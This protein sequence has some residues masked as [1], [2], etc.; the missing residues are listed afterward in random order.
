MV[1]G[2]SFGGSRPSQGLFW[3]GLPYV[4]SFGRLAFITTGYQSLCPPWGVALQAVCRCWLVSW[5]PCARAPAF[6]RALALFQSRGRTARCCTQGSGECRP[7]G[8]TLTGPGTLTA[9]DDGGF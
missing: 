1:A 8:A 5:F 2:A 4:R 6:P 3:G 9:R 7:E